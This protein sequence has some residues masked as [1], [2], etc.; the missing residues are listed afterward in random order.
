M[1]LVFIL[2]LSLI[3]QNQEVELLLET[4]KSFYKVRQVDSAYHYFNL[5]IEADSSSDEAWFRRGLT[6]EK[7]NDP[8]GALEDYR[9][10]AQISPEPVYYNNI[11]MIYTI[12][13]DHMAA[14]E[15]YDK[16]LALDPDYVQALFNKGIAYHHLGMTEEACRFVGKARE[17][18]FELAESYWQQFCQ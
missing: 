8:D 7:L 9:H 17:L 1:L 12:R 14:L 6:R 5:A 10:A 11:G 4:G 18:G 15:E 3:S 13:E 2:P 16:A